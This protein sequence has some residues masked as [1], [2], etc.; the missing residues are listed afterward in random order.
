MQQNEFVIV[1]ELM[2]VARALRGGCDDVVRTS[3]VCEAAAPTP[4][5]TKA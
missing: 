3:R 4:S 2:A 1:D 5:V